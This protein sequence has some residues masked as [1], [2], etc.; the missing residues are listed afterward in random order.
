MDVKQSKKSLWYKTL[1]LE[2]CIVDY[3]NYIY[4]LRF[5]R[6]EN[7]NEI[8]MFWLSKTIVCY[9]DDVDRL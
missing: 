9:S 6:Q 2:T 5:K 1:L 8:Q 4:Q 7:C 3:A